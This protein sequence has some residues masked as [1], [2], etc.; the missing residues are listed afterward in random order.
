MHTL[1]ITN[2]RKMPE[3]HKQTENNHHILSYAINQTAS[4]V[5]ITD[6]NGLIEYV[7]QRFC[8]I[9]GYS[10]EEVIGRNPRFLSYGSKSPEEYKQLWDTI[11]SGKEWKGEFHNKKKNNESFWEMA[12][13]TPVK[14]ERGVIT[15]FIA[16]KEDITEK[17]QTEEQINKLSQ[18]VQQNPCSIIITNSQ[19][20]IEYVNPSFTKNTGYTLEEVFGRNPRILKSGEISSDKYKQ[21]WDTIVSGM[22]WKGEFLNRKKDGSLFWEYG[23][24]SPI[25]DEKGE[26]SHFVSIKEDIT[27]RKNFETRLLYFANNDPLT[28]LYNRRRFREELLIVLAQSQRYNTNGVLLFLDL[29]NFKYVNDTL[30]HQK[31][32]Q[33]LIKLGILLRQRLRESDILARLGGDEFAV[34]LPH[35]NI[36]Q[37][38]L[39]AEQ[40]LELVREKIFMD[41]EIQPVGVSISIGIASFP[42]HGTNADKLLTF[43]DLAMYK[44]KE[45]GRNRICVYSPEHK[46]KVETQLIW[47]KR[48]REAIKN[49]KFLLYLQP[50]LSI[51][52]GGIGSYEALLRMKCE[53]G[54][55]VTPNNFIFIAEHFGLINE[56]DKWVVSRAIQIISEQE[57][58]KKG[59]FLEANI[60]GKALTNPELLDIIKREI[61]R[62]GIN[63][64]CLV[65][66]IT[67]TAAIENVFE[68]QNFI[69]ILKEIGCR[70]AIDDFGSGFSSLSNLKHLSVD[71]MKIDGSFI[72]DLPNNPVDQ[73]LVKAMVEIARWLGKQTIAEFVGSGDTV[74]LLKKLGVDFAQGFYIGKPGE[75]DLF[76]NNNHSK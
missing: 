22:V 23:S 73:H 14:N 76:M 21:L 54:E 8:K 4:V 71:Y 28:N 59:I 61:S 27:E 18:A 16:I 53:N 19:G 48:I 6:K 64:N 55:I 46:T 74:Q 30:G 5:M 65:L 70:F 7:N 41:D 51:R 69:N 47:E 56:I 10:S 66:E 58:D 40:I 3:Q 63:P 33:L 15:H 44:A 75:I 2:H 38:K 43:A 67:E 26:I 36:E 32:D 35:T 1:N 57:F 20:K 68:A 52:N 45:D 24:I 72:S 17:K 12:S 42:E 34:I 29:D 49:N 39:I 60:S 9:T 50:I 11:S 62:T 25:K 37:A 13:I 31:G